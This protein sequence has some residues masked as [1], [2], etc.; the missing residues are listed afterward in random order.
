MLALLL[1]SDLEGFFFVS[2]F[3]FFLIGGG[4]GGRGVLMFVILGFVVVGWLN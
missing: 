4:R 3:H 2:S 1:W